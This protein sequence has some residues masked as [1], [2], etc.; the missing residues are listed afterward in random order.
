MTTEEY[1]R[2]LRRKVSDV[3][4]A[5]RRRTDTELLEATS[6]V[7]F[8]LA[9]RQLDGFADITVGTSKANLATYGVQNASDDQCLLLMYGAAHAV[10]SATYRERVDRGELG[11]SWTSG[12]ESESS[13]SAEKAYKQMLDELKRSFEEL[14][15]TYQ[16]QTANARVH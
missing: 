4:V 8:E 9:M 16:R 14:T 6:D 3:D 10:L 13:I 12:L 11:I 15:I 1:L 5:A 7:R 2:M